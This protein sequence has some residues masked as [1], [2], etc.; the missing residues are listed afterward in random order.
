MPGS[1]T[2][3]TGHHKDP[4][5]NRLIQ[6]H[7]DRRPASERAES[8]D[9]VVV[10]GGPAGLLAARHLAAAGLA[11]T[12]AEATDQLGGR[13]ATERRD[14]FLLDRSAHPLVADRRAL[15]LLPRPLPL[16]RLSGGVALHGAAGVLRL[17]DATPPE[18]DAPAE[19]TA[20]FDRV[21]LR[22][23]LARFSGLP[24][25]RLHARPELTAAAALRARDI[26]DRIA[27]GALRPLLAALLGDPELVTSS[28]QS[29]LRLR[30]FAR[31][32]LALPAAGALT[33]LL[34]DGLPEGVT[35]RT[36]TRA[37]RVATTAVETERADGERGSIP[38]R[39]VVVATGVAEAARLL[40][41]LRRTP[42]GPATVLHHAVPGAPPGTPHGPALL[43]DTAGRGPVAYSVA[44]S[45]ADPARAPEGRTL[46]TS[47]VL[48]P[49]A[50]EPAELLDKA[51]RPQLT[52]LHGAPADEWELLS[53]RHDPLAAPLL[54][55][56]YAPARTTRLIDG[57]YVC[58]DH[59]DVPGLLGDLGSATRAARALLADAGQEP[60]GDLA[61][62]PAA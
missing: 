40:P 60:P 22:A 36:G 28:R 8:A 16:C 30:A 3:D 44:A 34:V 2:S 11:V 31:H 38:C 1:R 51:A 10:G 62:T 17:G 9:V 48:G 32:G 56:P 50:A 23:H 35:V 4:H 6:R 53:V 33:R 43:V 21:W 58:G 45:A 12:V 15:G 41:G 5:I 29:D 57:L 25:E 54:A 19:A 13:L 49:R 61:A 26:P 27:G 18:D 20:D 42:H 46:V 14:G 52:E 39:A 47:V 55:P 24:D 59:R 7:A 37:V